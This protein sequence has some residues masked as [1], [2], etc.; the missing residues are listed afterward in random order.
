LALTVN[1]AT[2]VAQPAT[3][4][5]QRPSGARIELVGRLRLRDEVLLLEQ[6]LES[7]PGGRGAWQ[8]PRI[9]RLLATSTTR[10]AASALVGQTVAIT[11]VTGYVEGDG[12]GPGRLDA[13]RRTFIVLDSVLADAAAASQPSAAPLSA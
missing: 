3:A 12:E 13:R 11:G 6:R 4:G 7:G 8:T 10:A 2:T 5:V 1:I 9:Y